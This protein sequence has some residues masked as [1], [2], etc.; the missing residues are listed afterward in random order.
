MAARG[1]SPTPHAHPLSRYTSS[2]WL[3][4]SGWP[5]WQ[6][7]GGPAQVHWCCVAYCFSRWQVDTHTCYCWHPKLPSVLVKRGAVNCAAW[8]TMPHLW[9]SWTSFSETSAQIL[10]LS[11]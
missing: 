9:D 6:I 7:W 8:C 4:Q 10:L 1:E 2:H 3:W 11:G 5:L